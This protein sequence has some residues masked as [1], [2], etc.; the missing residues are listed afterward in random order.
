MLQLRDF[1]FRIQDLNDCRVHVVYLIQDIDDGRVHV[2]HVLASH[3]GEVIDGQ[4]FVVD[5]LVLD[6]LIKPLNIFHVDLV[7]FGSV[8][9]SNWDANVFQVVIWW[10]RL[11]VPLH[12]TLASVI[13]ALESRGFVLYKLNVVFKIVETTISRIM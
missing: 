6:L 3:K 4:L 5:H 12:I 2:R 9:D 10:R 1:V 13:K 8:K 11:I 7:I